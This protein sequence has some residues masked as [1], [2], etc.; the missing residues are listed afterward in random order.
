MKLLLKSTV[1]AFVL[2]VIFSMIPFSAQCKNV[3]DNVFRLHILANS[4]SETDQNLK[5][6]VRDKVL[7]Y[8]ECL[9]KNADN[10]QNAEQ[11]TKES[12]QDIANVAQREVLDNGY[13]Y[14]VKAE[15][16]KIHFDTRCYENVTMPSGDYEALRITIGEGKGHNWWCVMY[17]SLCV[18]AATNYEELK[19]K[20]TDNEYKMMTDGGY[21][22]QF[23]VVEYFQNIVNFFHCT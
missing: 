20:T 2:T 12:L 22:V 5:L 17:P 19:D 1:I 14:Q 11:L 6:C 9:Y 3:S 13:S 10:L 16:R 15:V 7:E 23:K 8:T 21:D 4:D 18:G